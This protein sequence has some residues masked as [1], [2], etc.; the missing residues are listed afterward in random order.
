MSIE[1]F[2]KYLN[3]PRTRFTDMVFGLLDRD[4]SGQLDFR[5]V[6]LLRAACASLTIGCGWARFACQTPMLLRSAAEY[7]G[8]VW[9]FCSLDGRGLSRFTFELMDKEKKGHLTKVGVAA[10]LE[11]ASA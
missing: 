9:N 2:N 5:G 3:M 1:E 11:P 10:D 4:K 6:L 7:L 8:G